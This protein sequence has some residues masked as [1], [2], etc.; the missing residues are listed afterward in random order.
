MNCLTLCFITEQNN[1]THYVYLDIRSEQ[2]KFSR[3]C[4]SSLSDLSLARNCFFFNFKTENS[5]YHSG[6]SKGS[7][8][9]GI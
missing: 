4:E 3:K 6:V 7:F 9:S 5:D 2:V 8:S 1:D